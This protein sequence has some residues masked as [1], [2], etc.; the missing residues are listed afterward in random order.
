ML[1]GALPPSREVWVINRMPVLGL[2]GRSEAGRS[3]FADRCASCHSLDADHVGAGPDLRSIGART[4]GELLASIVDPNASI[5]PAQR[6]YV[7]ETED[8]ESWTGIV[9]EET[10]RHLTLLQSGSQLIRVPMA[11]VRE[12]RASALSLMPEGLTTDLKDQE[13]ADLLAYVQGLLTPAAGVRGGPG[14]E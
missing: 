11:G 8:G 6:A 2:P 13:L 5:E 3:L 10:D 4:P 7:V 1:D 14:P 9:R 12:V